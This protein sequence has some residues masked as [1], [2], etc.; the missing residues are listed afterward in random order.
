M[1]SAKTSR[2]RV[3][4]RCLSVVASF[5]ACFLVLEVAIRITWT[6]PWRIPRS[7][8]EPHSTF[9]FRL[10]PNH[11]F[12]IPIADAGEFAV[13]TNGRGF[14][15]P[16][17]SDIQGND[18]RVVSIGDSFTFGWGLPLDCHCMAQWCDSYRRSRPDTNLGHAFVALPKW[19]PKDYYFAYEEEVR[20]FGADI[21]VLGVFPGNDILPASA[22]RLIDLD[23]A[24]QHQRSIKASRRSTW[25][26]SRCYTLDWIKARVRAT[27]AFADALLEL[28]SRPAE[29][30]RFLVDRA[31]QR[32]LWETTFFYLEQLHK[33]VIEDGAQLIVLSYPSLI[34]CDSNTLDRN[35]DYNPE[36][37]DL[38]LRDFCEKNSIPMISLFNHLQSEREPLFWP[39]DRHMNATGQN[40]AGRLLNR[41]LSPL[42]DARINAA[43]LAA[44]T[45][46][47]GAETTTR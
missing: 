27:P 28:G 35:E 16:T 46:V 44:G 10:K 39:I 43:R 36:M 22:G 42:V 24:T 38:V 23:D 20:P 18:L 41:E 37:P 19:S 34:Q 40:V 29:L 11:S 7:A 31:H 33:R 14:R 15:G 3:L 2:R 1:S 12:R 21:V 30:D 5:I 32:C 25:H 6:T 9:Q 13:T 47:P 17:V 45:S 26:L 8:R 4:V